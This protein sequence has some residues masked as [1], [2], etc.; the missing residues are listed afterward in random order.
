MLTLNLDVNDCLFNGSIGT[1]CTILKDKNQKVAIL[2]VKFDNEETGRDLQ[3][4]HPL[5]KKKFPGLTPIKKEIHKYSLSKNSKAGVSNNATVQQFPLILSF[6]S[7]THK[8]QGQTVAAPRKVAIDLRS[9][10]GPNQAYVMLGRV[11]K[12]DQLFIIGELPENKI[13]TDKEA[14]KQLAIMKAKSVNVNPPVW[15]KKY[16]QSLRICFLNIHSIRDKIDDIR[17]DPILSYSDLIIFAETWLEKESQDD[18]PFL[19][20]NKYK[21]FLNCFGKG[22]GLAVYYKERPLEIFNAIL[23]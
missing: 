8:I 6:A 21:L 15:E 7:T 18:D 3:R 2:M 1:L 10:F 12:K 11:Q 17:A 19:Q 22:K 4:C 13:T 16:G 14:K 9:V 23:S 5:L 20:L